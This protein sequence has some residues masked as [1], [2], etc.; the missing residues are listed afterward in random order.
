M[1]K[2]G[3]KL[4]IVVV[5]WHAGPKPGPMADGHLF[6]NVTTD[7]MEVAKVAAMKA[8]A[9][10][11]GKA[12]VIVFADSACARTITTSFFARPTAPDTGCLAGLQ[13]PRFEIAP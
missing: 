8:I 4:M 3:G 6:V 7:A 12:G 5:G 13:P 10:S 11:N 2:N 1:V 9:D